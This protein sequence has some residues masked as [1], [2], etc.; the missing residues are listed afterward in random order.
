MIDHLVGRISKPSQKTKSLPFIGKYNT[1]D[2]SIKSKKYVDPEDRYEL[3]STRSDYTHFGITLSKVDCL[4]T[5]RNGQSQAY[6]YY[7]IAGSIHKFS[8]RGQH[9]HDQLTLNRFRRALADIENHFGID[10]TK[11]KLTSL[12]AGVNIHLSVPAARMIEAVKC[13]K[14]KRHSKSFFEGT[15]A[16]QLTYHL[17]QQEFKIYDKGMQFREKFGTDE[18]LLRIELAMTKSQQFNS[19]GIKSLSDLKSEVSW[20]KLGSKLVNCSNQLVIFENKENQGGLKSRE[21][22]ARLNDRQHWSS[23][24]KHTFKRHKMH[25]NKHSRINHLKTEILDLMKRE[26]EQMIS[27]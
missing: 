20:K 16:E 5:F 4:K 9:N 8:N 10:A 11:T 21:L 27:D 22:I 25:L 12:E 24:D 15:V 7:S 14:Q 17:T 2:G 13:Y 6:Q 1:V 23:I 3:I 26:I 18:N 19:L